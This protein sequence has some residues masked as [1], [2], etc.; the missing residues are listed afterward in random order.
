M[1]KKLLLIIILMSAAGVSGH[2]CYKGSVGILPGISVLIGSVIIISL[3]IIE[4]KHAK[5]IKFKKLMQKAGIFYKNQEFANAIKVFDESIKLQ[6]GSIE[7]I[8]GKAQCY[9]MLIQYDKALDC[10]KTAREISPKNSQNYFISGLTYLH[11]GEY[12]KA[13]HAFIEIE[14]KYPEII[15]TYYL[16]GQIFEKMEKLEDSLKYYRKYLSK[17]G[18]LKED[19]LEK[20]EDV[21]DKIERKAKNKE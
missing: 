12:E 13:L 21:M 6:P 3:N 11:M 10:C 20:I 5:K 15:D 2:L 4:T 14:T 17:G 8:L 18:I 7:P 16:I 19:V 1:I 9:R